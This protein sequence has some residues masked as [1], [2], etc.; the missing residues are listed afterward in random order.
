MWRVAGGD[1]FDCILTNLRIHAIQLAYTTI[2]TIPSAQN[3]SGVEP[4]QESSKA[5][6]QPPTIVTLSG[7]L[8]ARSRTGL[9]RASRAIFYFVGL[10]PY[11]NAAALF[12]FTIIYTFEFS[13]R[14]GKMTLQNYFCKVILPPPAFLS[15]EIKHF[16]SFFYFSFPATLQLEQKCIILEDFLKFVA[17]RGRRFIRLHISLSINSCNPSSK[18]Y[19]Y[20]DSFRSE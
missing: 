13:A 6:R 14:L 12:F 17:G 9:R 15:S 2:I 3:D 10:P 1:S 20:H 8:K 11:K 16:S 4:L 7:A 19:Y 5:L 18:Y